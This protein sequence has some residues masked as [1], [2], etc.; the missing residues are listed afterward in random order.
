MGKRVTP[1]DKS[2]SKLL[3]SNYR[4]ISIQ[5]IPLKILERVIYEQLAGYLKETS[6]LD[7]YQSGFRRNFS[8]ATTIIDV[9]DFIMDELGKVNYVGVIFLDLAKA[10]DGVDHTILLSKLQALGIKEKEIFWF[11]SYLDKRKQ[12]SLINGCMSEKVLQKP[13]G[14]PQ[15]SVLGLLLFL[16]HV[17]DVA[18]NVS[19]K[20]HPY[21]DYTVL[22]VADKCAQNIEIKLNT[23]LKK[24]HCSC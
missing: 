11:A 5:P 16:T 7:P 10:F 17:N 18:S 21:A 2:G 15:G 20:S 4:P 23:E 9:A 12:V 24:A 8:T 22:L 19:C 3:C 14:V 13:F 6:I 1:I